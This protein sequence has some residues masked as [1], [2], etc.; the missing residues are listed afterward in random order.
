MIQRLLTSSKFTFF[1]LKISDAICEVI[2]GRHLSIVTKVLDRIERH[3]LANVG[4]RISETVI[5][6]DDRNSTKL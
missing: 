3:H 1:A 5:S 2:G 4:K 6:F